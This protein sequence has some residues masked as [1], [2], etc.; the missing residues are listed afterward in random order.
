MRILVIVLAVLVMLAGAAC[1]AGGAT[2]AAVFGPN[3]E[4]NSGSEA[5]GSDTSALVFEADDV[6]DEEPTEGDLD[7]SDIEIKISAESAEE[8]GEIFVGL[9][10][11]DE[12]D[13]YLADFEHEVVTDVELDPFELSTVLSGGDGTADPPGDQDIWLAS[14]SGTGK[15]TIQ[16]GLETGDLRVVIMNADGSPGFEVDGSL[17][18]KVPYIFWIALGILGIGAL[19][20]VGGIVAIVLAIKSD[21]KKNTPS[22]SPPAPPAPPPADPPSPMEPPAT[23]PDPA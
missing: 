16:H 10:Q 7:P 3:G 14:A 15:Q 21:N 20:V 4:F 23:G 13:A 1:A 18:V 19:M 12:V 9:G 2:V 8:G 5:F 6:G 22:A 11:A 17:G